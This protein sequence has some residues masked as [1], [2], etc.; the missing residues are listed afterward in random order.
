MQIVRRGTA[1]PTMPVISPFG[2]PVQLPMVRFQG[3]LRTNIGHDLANDGNP[4]GTNNQ[5]LSTQLLFGL[6][7]FL[8]LGLMYLK[9]TL[10]RRSNEPSRAATPKEALLPQADST[11]PATRA[12]SVICPCPP[13]NF[14]NYLPPMLQALTTFHAV[15]PPANDEATLPVP[16]SSPP[17]PD[18]LWSISPPPGNFALRNSEPL[19]QAQS[20]ANSRNGSDATLNLQAPTEKSTEEHPPISTVA[21][22]HIASDA[23]LDRQALGEDQPK[24][25]SAPT[26]RNPSAGSLFSFFSVGTPDVQE[27]DPARKKS[28]Q[29]ISPT[30]S[31]AS[32]HFTDTDGQSPSSVQ[33]S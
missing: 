28:V 9:R 26:S 10:T 3:H 1:N 32:L 30:D 15:R 17:A 21:S 12:T 7:G 16:S 14:N 11:R 31:W 33:E 8:G 23:T 22:S 19:E 4:A 6:L 25:P 27:E 5:L 20:G 2:Q 29:G 13:Y 18:V 24:P